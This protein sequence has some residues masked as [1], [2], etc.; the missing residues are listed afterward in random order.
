MTTRR[1]VSLPRPSRAAGTSTVAAPPGR[2][3]RPF[4]GRSV[5]LLRGFL[6]V[7]F[8]V[9]GCQKLANPHFFQANAPGSFVAQ[10]RGSIVTSPLHHLLSPALHAPVV[11]AV[12]I[13]FGE[14]AVG[15]GTLLGLLTTVA[16]IG[17]S[18]LSLLFFLTV[19]FNDSPYYY[20]ADIVFFFAWTPLLLDGPSDWSLDALFARRAA[21]ARAAVTAAA[22]GGSAT[23]RRR[24]DELERRAA[25]QRLSGIGLTAGL[26]LV[27][28]GAADALGRVV[29]TGAPTASTPRVGATPPPSS[30]TSGSTVAAA[31]VPKGTLIGP[32]SAVPVGGAASFTDPAQ[33]IPAYVVQPTSGDFK[34]FSA[35]CTHAGC[36]V[37]FDGHQEEFFCPCHGSTFSARSGAVLGGPAPTALPSIPIALGSNGQ[38]YVD[39]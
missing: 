23:A 30:S 18:C 17:G 37:E 15:I 36:Q 29:S 38:L 5:L 22:A 25:L 9:A 4:A 7:T 27:L 20:G 14:L 11:I 35:I 19:S 16:A 2:P 10:L 39:G 31:G 24:A 6:G 26:V 21:E 1:N 12:L 3:V 32:A 13:S 28:G 33:G 8:V 34:A